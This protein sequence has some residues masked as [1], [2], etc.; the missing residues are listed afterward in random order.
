MKDISLQYPSDKKWSVQLISALC[1][2]QLQVKFLNTASGE[3]AASVFTEVSHL[4]IFHQSGDNCFLTFSYFCYTRY[5]GSGFLYQ[6]IL[7]S[8]LLFSLFL[9]K[10]NV[11]R[12]KLKVGQRSPTEIGE[13]QQK[14]LV[15]GKR[16]MRKDLKEVTQTGQIMTR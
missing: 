12:N 5:M 9:L 2:R 6:A 10:E 16:F 8:H 11:S 4:N 1:L 14:R 13:E 3:P 7:H 15:K